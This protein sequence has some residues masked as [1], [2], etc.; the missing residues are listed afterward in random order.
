[1]AR[2]VKL[3][4]IEVTKEEKSDVE[5]PVGAYTGKMS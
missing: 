3:A 4:T 2:N 5:V 1:V